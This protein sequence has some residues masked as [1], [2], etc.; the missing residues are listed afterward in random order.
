[1]VTGRS[2]RLGHH[3]ESLVANQQFTGTDRVQTQNLSIMEQTV[4]D[5][6]QSQRHVML[7]PTAQVS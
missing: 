6:T 5:L 2:G 3:A 4:W 7:G 1:M